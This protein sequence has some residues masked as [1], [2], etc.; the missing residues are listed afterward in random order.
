MRPAIPCS[1][2]AMPF[3]PVYVHRE[4]LNPRRIRNHLFDQGIS[5][6]ADDLHVTVV[7]SKAAMEWDSI[8]PHRGSILLRAARRRLELFG[9]EGSHL[10][11]LVDHPYLHDRAAAWHMAGARSDFPEYR[12]HVTLHKPVV[13]KSLRGR[14]FMWKALTPQFEHIQPYE[15]DILLGPEQV[16][17]LGPN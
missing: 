2:S 8:E 16:G 12:P 13:L 10:V 5:P 15:D 11:L 6:V 1:L 3:A 9:P 17:P 7:Y 4:V 14:P